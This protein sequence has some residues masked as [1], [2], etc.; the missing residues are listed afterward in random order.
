MPTS[1]N[2]KTKSSSRGWK[3]IL[4]L[5]SA[6][7][8]VLI[9]LILL[10]V[11]KLVSSSKVNEII[12]SKIRE[13]TGGEV[14]FADLSMSWTWG[15]KIEDFSFRDMTGRTMVKAELISIKPHYG[16]LVMGNLSFGKTIIDKPQ[17]EIE[18][19]ESQDEY[20]PISRIVTPDIVQQSPKI[21]LPINK[22]DLNIS[23]GSLKVTD[24]NGKSVS[25][26]KINSKV[27]LRPPGQKTNFDIDMSVVDSS[28]H[29]KIHAEG[30]LVPSAKTGWNLKGSDGEVTVRIDNLDLGSLSSFFAL[31]G[32]ELKAKGKISA[33]VAMQ[34]KNGQLR[35]LDAKLDG[36][37]ID[38]TVDQLGVGQLKTSNLTVLAKLQHN[39]ETI[40]I[41]KLEIKS[42]WL[43]AKA[44][45]QI[46]K[47]FDSL[48]DFVQ[49]DSRYNLDAEFECDLGKLFSLM[50][51]V[52]GLKEDV[53]ITSGKLSASIRT[54]S[55]D[56]RRQ[57]SGRADLV[58]LEGTVGA[59]R[60]S[61][62]EPIVA[63]VEI[64]S[65]GNGIRY[66]KLDISA[67][68]A[69]I[70][71]RGDNELLE[72][73]TQVDLASLQ[74]ELGQFVDLGPYKIA[75]HI[76]S[77]TQ[78]SGDKNKISL[79][80]LSTVKDLQLSSDKNESI[81]Q[82][83]IDISFS[84]FINTNK[85]I[86][87][88][89]SVRAEADF[90]SIGLE[91]TILP[92]KKAAGPVRMKILADR[93]DLEKLRPFAVFFGFLPQEMQI[94]GTAKS[95][96]FLEIDNGIY[97]IT[98]DMTQIENLKLDYP[99]HEP[100]SMDKVSIVFDGD[101]DTA[102]KNIVIRDFELISPQIKI[103]GNFKKSTRNS[104]TK[105]QGKLDCEYDW[106]AVSA[107]VAPYLPKG[108]KLAGKRKDL[109]RFSSEYP[110]GNTDKLLANLNT[111]ARVGFDK[112]QYMGMNI[113]TTE[114]DIRV[115]NGLLEIAPFSA[116]V[117]E[118]WLNFAGKADF[119]KRP[120]LLKTPGPIDIIKDVKIYDETGEEL[121]K[122]L[123]P[124]FASAFNIRGVANFRCDKLAIPLANASR[125]DLEI[126]GTVSIKKM[127]MESSDLL[128]QILSF[129][130]AGTGNQ[131]I[132]VHPTKFV[133]HEGF[134]RYDNM[135]I[136][137]GNNPINFK[138]VIGLDKSLNMTV[139]LP[140]TLRGRTT[141]TGE[142]PDGER[143]TLVLKGTV[144]KPELDL[145]KLLEDQLK[146]QLE[147]IL[148][149]GLEGFFKTQP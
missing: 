94:Y 88:I 132:T 142:E 16:A 46:P 84:L 80:G 4:K 65:D 38:L 13:L 93:I 50:P 140:Y 54:F 149:E 123:N 18:L 98:T 67:P 62:S 41:D 59:K 76:S 26:S 60:V 1:E 25:L 23:Q 81:S 68:F 24:E 103:K 44:D 70:S 105:L 21:V 52:F 34:I 45:G 107:M 97:K 115:H 33:D 6:F 3:F 43:T 118:G 134:L 143:I 61:L 79:T 49:P 113:G 111:E 101:I 63:Q 48:A 5:I 15:F 12:L 91:D 147:S 10:L 58:D 127:R 92:L 11:P 139:T 124:I 69:Q 121:L 108:F 83:K 73:D 39:K 2:S 9:L 135:Q 125:N 87:S 8:I 131:D 72:C 110:A 40:S 112:A 104:R 74:D 109:V 122:Y 32:F 138:G 35:R 42:D 145:G 22:I 78:I 56:S 90:G 66:E 64:S 55:E 128:S 126:I 17:V 75:G 82:D 27:N 146:K 31:A 85:N 148:Q 141:R 144:D 47:T 133:L 95:Q 57:I 7:L 89:K 114:I 106:I 53:K 102:G 30:K 51:S 14:D 96:V 129:I 71:G 20:E 36:S 37:N 29:S 100:F 119:N 117:N 137:V 116:P 120:V 28:G 86:L 19:K 136:D 99:D 77:K 130:G